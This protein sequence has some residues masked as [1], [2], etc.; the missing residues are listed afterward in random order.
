[1]NSFKPLS[2]NSDAL[3]PALYLDCSVPRETLIES[4]GHRLDAIRDL[5]HTMSLVEGV[6]ALGAEDLA[7]FGFVVQLLASDASE[8][9]DAALLVLPADPPRT[10]PTGEDE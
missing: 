2:T 3:K 1:M 10:R 8:L 9:L 5:A 6:G 7:A 4:A